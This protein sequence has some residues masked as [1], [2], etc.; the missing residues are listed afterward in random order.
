[1]RAHSDKRLLVISLFAALFFYVVDTFFG[2][3]A[4]WLLVLVEFRIFVVDDFL[5]R[6]LRAHM[7]N[8]ISSGMFNASSSSV[9]TTSGNRLDDYFLP[10]FVH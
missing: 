10:S 2:P 7:I 6:R 9:S 5:N 8:H 4:G 3:F 1:M